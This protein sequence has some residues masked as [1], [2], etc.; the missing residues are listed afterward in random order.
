MVQMIGIDSPRF[1]ETVD[2]TLGFI[3]V[4][5]SASLIHDEAD[6]VN[7]STITYQPDSRTSITLEV[8]TE[9]GPDTNG[10]VKIL[11]CELSSFSSRVSI[12]S[13][14]DVESD[15]GAILSYDVVSIDSSAF[16]D[17]TKLVSIEIPD[18]IELIPESAFDGCSR[19]NRVVIYGDVPIAENAFSGCSVLGFIIHGGVTKAVTDGSVGVSYTMDNSHFKVGDLYFPDISVALLYSDNDETI[20]MVADTSMGYTTISNRTLDLGGFE[21]TLTSESGL[22]IMGDSTIRN[23][24]INDISDEG[25]DGGANGVRTSIG[26]S[27][28]V[29]DVDLTFISAVGGNDRDGN[30]GYYV[31]ASSELY[32]KGDS[33]I[34]AKGSS[35]ENYNSVGIILNGNKGYLSV[36]PGLTI[37]VGL[38]GICGKG[39]TTGTTMIIDGAKISASN[40]YGIYHPQEGDLTISGG[41]EITGQTGLEI[42]RGSLTITDANIIATGEYKVE[43]N[44]GGTTTTGAAIA[45]SPYGSSTQSE[46]VVK[47]SD[48]TYEGEVAF[49]QANPN[50]VGDVAYD[51]SISGGVFKSTGTDSDDKPYP[52][53]VTADG[54]VEGKFVT[55]GTFQSGGVSD[56]SVSEYMDEDLVMGEDGTVYPNSGEVTL[57]PEPGVDIGAVLES[58]TSKADLT[59]VLEA[60]AE[61]TMTSNGN[62]NFEGKNLEIEGNGATVVLSP[63]VKESQILQEV[64]IELWY[65]S[66]GAGDY[67]NLYDSTAKISDINFVVDD[68]KGYCTFVVAFFESIEMSGCTFEDASVNLNCMIT[69]VSSG[70]AS[71]LAPVYSVTDCSWTSPGESIPG[72]Y[73]LTVAANIITIEGCDIDGYVHGINVKSTNDKEDGAKAA[74][75]GTRVSNTEGNAVQFSY[76]TGES[77]VTGCEFENCGTGICVYENVGNDAHITSSQN[78]FVGCESDFYYPADD[79]GNVGQGSLSSEGDLFITET[80]D[81][82]DPVVGSDSETAEVPDVPVDDPVEV[83]DPVDGELTLAFDSADFYIADGS[84]S[85]LD[86]NP[87]CAQEA[88]VGFISSDTSVA[89]VDKNGVVTVITEGN[90]TITA[91]VNLSNG[92]VVKASFTVNAVRSPEVEGITFGTVTEVMEDAVGLIPVTHDL[93][94]IR[95]STILNLEASNIDGGMFTITYEDLGWMGINAENY[96]D[97]EYYVYHYTDDGTTVALDRL[98]LSEATSTGLIVHATDFSPFRFV[99]GIPETVVDPDQDTPD[100]PVVD[101]DDD[102][103]PI[104]PIVNDSSG[105]SDDTVTIVACA[106]AAVVA[107]LMAVFLILTYR[108]G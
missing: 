38:M 9:P 85:T 86:L 88:Q 11:S 107:A 94:E 59:I 67:S 47:V 108:K 23:G 53:I 57:N 70:T 33:S 78:R 35:E 44:S 73:A 40:G 75:S 61:Y 71:E 46:V 55:G 22:V 15:D 8:I 36:E 68:T 27:L 37:D 84:V 24:S 31:D 99:Y 63:V 56:D 13:T 25:A 29:E 26:V 95:G 100:H 87:E 77:S 51:F 39:T 91:L 97:F 14:I 69:M 2:Q 58:Y 18:S 62:R 103:A 21:L 17:K 52:A 98:L 5:V 48:G 7:G 74:V 76:E 105:T 102:Y 81:A 93:E 4:S 83:R 43:P 79:S 80:G 12:P 41:T 20:T 30:F 90:A 6:A 28:I 65:D 104:P 54:E 106:A 49:S 34:T 64:K 32:I 3:L 72:Y 92:D 16:Q 10:T 1:W 19:L 50:N 45:V 96:I 82:K 101:P 66:N 89:T 60:G 42:R